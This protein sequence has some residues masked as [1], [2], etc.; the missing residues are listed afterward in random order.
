VVK[1]EFLEKNAENYIFD[2][3]EDVKRQ[4]DIRR[5]DLK[6]RI[7][8][9]SD[10]IIK[11][12]ELNQINLIKLSKEANQLKTNIEKSRKDLNELIAQFDT[13]EFNDEKFNDIKA[14]V[15]VVNQEFNK[16]LAEYQYSLIGNKKYILEF[17]ELPIENIFGRVLVCNVSLIIS[18]FVYLI[19]FIC[20]HLNNSYGAQLL[21]ISR[22]L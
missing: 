18:I 21:L 19:M 16:I 12:V 8:I 10:E 11:S 6:F 22:T 17:K 15:V 4:V 3:Y 20:L 1:I 13:L 9:N 5:E 2:Y 7:D 14:T